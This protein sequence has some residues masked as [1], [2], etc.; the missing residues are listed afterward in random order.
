M[1][2]LAQSAPAGA[3][4]PVPAMILVH[5]SGGSGEREARYTADYNKMGIA[6]FAVDS[7]APRGIA[8]TTVD[9]ARAELFEM[10][11]LHRGRRQGGAHYLAA[12]TPYAAVY[13]KSPVGNTY[14]AGIEPALAAFLQNTAQEAVRDYFS[15]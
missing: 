9:Q 14:T 1:Q 8:S 4:R 7:F 5:G 6:V 13:G 12:C 10:S 3:D 15:N 11:R 2:L